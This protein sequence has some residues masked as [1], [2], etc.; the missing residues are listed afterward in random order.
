MFILTKLSGDD[1]AD[2]KY[3]GCFKIVAACS[4]GATLLTGII[5]FILPFFMNQGVSFVIAMS[6]FLSLLI[7]RVLLLSIIS[8][9]KKRKQNKLLQ[10]APS[11]KEKMEL[12]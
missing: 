1:Y 11:S 6:L 3:I 8:F 9:F 12:L 4:L 2:N 10:S 5:G 7:L